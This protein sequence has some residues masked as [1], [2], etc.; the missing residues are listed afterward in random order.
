[1]E[2]MAKKDDELSVE[3]DE[4]K[5]K[6]Q[7]NQGES[8]EG[9]NSSEEGAASK[10]ISALIVIVI[11]LIWL[12]VFIVLVKA[13]V[14][15]FGSNVLA[16]VVQDVPVIN[17]ILPEG[18]VSN[19]SGD[20]DYT[21]EEAIDRIKELEMEL[22]SQSSTSGVD[23]S[24]IVQLEAEIERLQEFEEQQDKF[25]QQKREFD[26]E[27][28]YTDNAPNIE[29]YQKYYEQMNPDN[30]A[31]I[32]RQVVEEE[33][34]NERVESAA[35]RYAEMEPSSAA[36]ILDEMTSA[37][38]DLVCAILES[39]DSEQSGLILEAMDSNVAAKVTKRMLSE[40]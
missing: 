38:L 15:G 13:D 1:M 12:G 24:Y 22:D 18:S 40:D 30:A 14:G 20:Y 2:K 23:S 31:E 10:I 25:A 4:K 21:L 6:K 33:Q 39:M 11:V 26:E 17:K 9:K 32:Y 29:E 8:R 35:K 16:P 5:A 19:A 7:K 28:V 34:Y 27:V 36:A 3:K 37:D